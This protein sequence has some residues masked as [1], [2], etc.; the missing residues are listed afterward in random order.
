MVETHTITMAGGHDDRDP[1]PVMMPHP[2]GQWIAKADYDSIAAELEQ[3]KARV[4]ELSD[5]KPAT[6]RQRVQ[7]LD[8]ALRQGMCPRPYPDN[9]DEQ[10][11]W[12]VDFGQCGCG[13]KAAL[14]SETPLKGS[15]PL[16]EL[17]AEYEKDPEMKRL[18]DAARA[19]LRSSLETKADDGL[20][21]FYR[22][23]PKCSQCGKPEPWVFI[24]GCPEKC[25]RLPQGQ[26]GETPAEHLFDGAPFSCAPYSS[27]R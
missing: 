13:M 22:P 5:M 1:W 15:I 12:C 9:K 17:I 25:G 23:E 8:A 2:N 11:G 16:S 18:L 3:A 24:N 19:E 27:K 4:I 21:A 26:S 6:L 14:Q 10:V 20:P 7:E